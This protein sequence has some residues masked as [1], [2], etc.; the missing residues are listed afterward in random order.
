MVNTSNMVELQEKVQEVLSDESFAKELVA[1]E[2]EKQV[3]IALEEKGIE[4]S[5]DEIRQ[6]GETVRKF[7]NGEISQEQLESMADGELSEEEL[8]EVAGGTS[9]IGVAVVL[10]VLGGFGLAL[11][12]G[13]SW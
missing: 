10:L 4:L 3:Q 5:L 2:D 12:L 9:P 13:R 7:Q 1:M 6:I 8:G 11:G